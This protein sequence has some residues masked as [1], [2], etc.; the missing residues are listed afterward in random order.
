MRV[1]CLLSAFPGR[2]IDVLV[3]H[4]RVKGHLSYSAA[5]SIIALIAVGTYIRQQNVLP[6][7]DKPQ[8]SN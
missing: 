6:A 4:Q 1:L 7:S 3:W 8:E 2:I 5:F